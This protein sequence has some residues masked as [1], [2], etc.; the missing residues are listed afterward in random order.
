[1]K[2]IC[3]HCHLLRE[4]CVCFVFWW[5][6]SM[7]NCIFLHVHPCLIIFLPL[8]VFLVSRS[9]F[10]TYLSRV[11]SIISVWLW[12]PPKKA[13]TSNFTSHSVAANQAWKLLQQMY[14]YKKTIFKPQCHSLCK[15]TNPFCV[16]YFGQF[17]YCL[18][19]FTL[20]STI[21]FFT[22]YFP[23][24]FTCKLK[25][26]LSSKHLFSWFVYSDSRWIMERCVGRDWCRS[27]KGQRKKNKT[28]IKKGFEPWT[29]DWRRLYII[30]LLLVCVELSA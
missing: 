11:S 22:A 26:N 17:L 15:Q 12:I 2:P 18:Y 24:L 13:H 6:F 30:Q 29:E 10:P 3:W 1:M 19:S 20:M 28:Q 21:F 23:F 7:Q 27:Q 16:A 5:V 9:I 14:V 25:I 8:L 4:N